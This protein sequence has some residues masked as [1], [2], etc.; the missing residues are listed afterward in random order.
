MTGCYFTSWGRGCLTGLRGV[1]GGEGGARRGERGQRSRAGQG[2]TLEE[3]LVI[4]G[5]GGGTKTQA[6][7]TV[8][9]A[10][11]LRNV[12]EIITEPRVAEVSPAGCPVCSVRSPPQLIQAPCPYTGIYFF[13]L[14][15]YSIV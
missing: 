2:R 5:R 3:G 9:T 12:R 8:I 1:G 11:V 13:S 6:R 7:V 10:A 4:Q 14:F 15:L